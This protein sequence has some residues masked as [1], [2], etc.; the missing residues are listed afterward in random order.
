MGGG[1]DENH[2]PKTRNHAR[3]GPRTVPRRRSDHCRETESR[4]RSVPYLLPI[5]I[6]ERSGAAPAPLSPPRARASSQT[7]TTVCWLCDLAPPPMRRRRERPRRK[8][9]R[10]GPSP[11]PPARAERSRESAAEQ[12][13][14]SQARPPPAGA[15]RPPGGVRGVLI[16]LQR[17]AAIMIPA[18]AAADPTAT[19][20]FLTSARRPVWTVRT[21]PGLL[22]DWRRRLR[23]QF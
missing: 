17:I 21:S 4:R 9:H 14:C 20:R 12:R 5:Q 16:S 8:P 3:E 18:T 10:Q 13:R 2:A 22:H 1:K 23:L 7:R 15:R 19:A 6:I 11:P